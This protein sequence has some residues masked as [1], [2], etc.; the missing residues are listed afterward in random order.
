MPD[1]RVSNSCHYRQELLLIFDK[2][3]QALKTTFRPIMP[4]VLW[5]LVMS[6]GMVLILKPLNYFSFNL[7]F[8]RLILSLPSSYQFFF[9][10]TTPVEPCLRWLSTV[11]AG[12]ECIHLPNHGKGKIAAHK[13]KLSK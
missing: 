12:C 13:L 11:L 7:R 8:Y 5:Y 1:T 3:Y 6:Q 10:V 2:L 4:P 9:S